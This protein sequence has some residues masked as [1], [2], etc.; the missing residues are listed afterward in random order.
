MNKEYKSRNFITIFTKG[1]IFSKLSYVFCGLANIKYGQVIKG[2]LFFL[3]EVSYF[4]F[5]F[6]KGIGLLKNLA[7][8]GETEQGMA[9][10]EQVGIFEMQAGDN[11]MLILLS[12]VV[13]IVVTLCFIAVWLFSIISGENARY[14]YDN[15]HH[16]NN[17]VEDVKSLFNDRIHF[18]L[19]AI[20]VI[21]LATFTVMPLIY[22]ILMAF[23]NYDNE[24]QP[25]GHL[26]DWVGLKNFITLLS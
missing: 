15:G 20:P 26:F 3:L 19:L 17:F 10:N 14:N 9:F 21:G 22:M 4:V 5:M 11:S 2:L 18:L 23:T 16:I 25:P 13:A 24:H 8:L 6:T 12:G 1:D 7:T